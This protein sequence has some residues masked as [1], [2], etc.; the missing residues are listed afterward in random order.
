[1]SAAA[2]IKTELKTH[3]FAASAWRQVAPVWAALERQCPRASFFLSEA[4]VETWLET[5]GPGLNVSILVFDASG[6]A[7]GACLLVS[8]RRWSVTVPVRRIS[9]NASGEADFESTYIEFNDLLCR[10]GYEA[11]IA[12]AVAKHLSRQR[13]DEVRLDGLCQGPAYDA[14]KEALE[15]FD[16]EENWKPSYFVDLAAIRKKGTAYEM[17][18][19]GSNRRKLRERTRYQAEAGPPASGMRQ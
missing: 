19:S 6:V 12:Q 13:W 15:R 10:A 9:L 1:M 2:A 7:V 8:S 3:I 5:F 17:A 16:L 14:L 4:W 18:L 11:A